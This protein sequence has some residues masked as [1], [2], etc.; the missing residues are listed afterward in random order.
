MIEGVVN[1]FLKKSF[2]DPSDIPDFH[3]EMWSWCCSN[4]KFVAIAA[5]RGFAKSTAIT[6]SYT[7]ANIVFRL[8]SFVLIVADT[9][10]QA[11]FFLEDIKKELSTNED[12]MKMFGIRGYRKTALPTSSW[13]L[14]TAI[15]AE[16]SPR[17]QGNL[18]G[19]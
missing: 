7:I 1:A 9:E 15:S 4:Y 11:S 6:H 18:F 13:T 12:L 5:P 14:T 3:R 19:V 2:D 17:A 8:R 10:T 16:S